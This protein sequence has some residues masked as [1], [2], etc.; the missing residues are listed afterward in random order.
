MRS[1]E[2]L[3]R[4]CHHADAWG[5]DHHAIAVLVLQPVP[6]IVLHADQLAAFIS[7]ARTLDNNLIRATGG[8][9]E[10]NGGIGAGMWVT[11]AIAPGRERLEAAGL[12]GVVVLGQVEQLEIAET[13]KEATPA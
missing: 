4:I 10:V 9:L 12:T 1:I 3:N 6:R 5:F 8:C 7:W 2:Q 11:V 13:R